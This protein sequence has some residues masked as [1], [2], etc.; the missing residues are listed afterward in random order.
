AVVREQAPEAMNVIEKRCAE[1]EVTML[2]EG[3]DFSLASRTQG[4]GGQVL[5]IGTP[6]TEY[7]DLL[8][9]IHGKHAARHAAA[10]G[11]A[12]ESLAERE[13]T[14]D[15]VAEALGGARSPGR[16]EVVQRRPLIVLDGAHNPAAAEAL[17]E[18]LRET[19]TWDRLH[20]VV[21]GF[22]NHDIG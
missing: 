17:A 19:F 15:A 14:P 16:I 22:S 18:A 12:L 7:A 3:R 4:I 10:A 11:V 20:L 9:P 1:Y 13:L 21:A 8:L 6:R 5:S 2:L